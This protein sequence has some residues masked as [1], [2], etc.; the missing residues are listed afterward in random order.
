MPYTADLDSLRS[1]SVPSWFRDAKLGIFVHWTPAAIPAFAPL[2]ASPFELAETDGWSHAFSHSPYVEWY[3]NSLSIPGSPVA[4][5][6]ARHWSGTPY[7]AFG[8]QFEAANRGWD[9]SSWASLFSRVG[10]RYV[11]LVTKHHDGFTLWPSAVRN[12]HRAERW[13]TARDLVG[14]LG[15][16]VRAR[17]M[18]Y[19][20]YYSGGL[21]WTFGGLPIDSWPAMMQAIPQTEEY[22]AYANAHWREL[23]DRYG[24]DVLWNDIGYPVAGRSA[25][26]FADYYNTHPDGLVNNRFDFAGA[27]RG[28]AHADFT[29]PEYASETAIRLDMWESTRGIGRSFGYNADEGDDDLM[30]VPELVHL[31]VDIVSKGGNLLLNVGPTSR[32]EIPWNQTLRLLG[33]GEWLG[34]NGEAVFGTRPSDRAAGTTAEGLSVRF[35]SKDDALFACVLGTPADPRASTVEI[36]VRPSA[37]SSVTL[38]GHE[39]P[40]EWVAT[41]FGCR[42]TLP[43]PPSASPGYALRIDPRPPRP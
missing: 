23:I 39:G 24:P 27:R 32:G 11:V 2:S 9:P 7:D 34:R 1:H 43:A 8:R 15:E 25:Q 17:G 40:L 41:D 28:T 19:G 37:A 33:L 31:F 38:L 16:A 4:E 29:T 5:F 14:D 35:T 22:A 18:R 6:H 13:G 21:D 42:V 26:L 30:S 36:D 3:Q 10:A 12:P 20:L